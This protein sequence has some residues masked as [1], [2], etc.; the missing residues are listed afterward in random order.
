MLERSLSHRCSRLRI[1]AFAV[2][3]LAAAVAAVPAAAQEQTGDLAGTVRD[4]G[5]QPL[6][7]VTVSVTAWARRA[8]R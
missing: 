4:S 8:S 5:G 2:V 7:G 6:P 1:V 3:L